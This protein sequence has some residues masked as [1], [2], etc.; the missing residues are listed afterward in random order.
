M[1][2]IAQQ[3]QTIDAHCPRWPKAALPLAAVLPLTFLISFVQ[4][5][6]HSSPLRVSSISPGIVET[7]FYQTSRFGDEAGAQKF[8]GQMKVLQACVLERL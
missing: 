5:R 8:Y 6:A 1:R 3:L 4:A 7:E 2:S